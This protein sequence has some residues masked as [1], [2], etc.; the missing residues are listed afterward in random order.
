MDKDYILE[1]VQQTQKLPALP[2]VTMEILSLLRVDALSLNRLI[3]VIKC[4]P[5]L[6]ATVLRV[7][8]SPL[9]GM[10][11]Q[12]TSL[13][14]ATM[15]VGLNTVKMLVLSASLVDSLRDATASNF[16]HSGYWR[17]S[18][19]TAVAALPL[20]RKATPNKPD[21]AFL[22]GLL[23]DIG[24]LAAAIVTPGEYLPVLDAWNRQK[25]SLADIEMME[26]GITHAEIGAAL[27]RAWD[28]PELLCDVVAAHT[29]QMPSTLPRQTLE[30]ARVVRAASAIAEVFCHDLPCTELQNVKDFCHSETGV[31]NDVIESALVALGANVKDLAALLALP[32]GYTPSYETIQEEL[33]EHLERLRRKPFRPVI[34]EEDEK[35]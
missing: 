21:D 25:G 15:V 35:R 28:L 27:L 17:R 23:S 32:I 3:E 24:V 2:A 18:L 9:Y 19:F 6:C 33:N 13:K 16:D 26:L 10:S 34:S 12:V 30:L 20:A 8:N 1:Q 5:S 22:A 14:Q 7:V 4:D 29:G 31:A 11:R